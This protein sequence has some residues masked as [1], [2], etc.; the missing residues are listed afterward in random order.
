MHELNEE[1]LLELQRLMTSG[2]DELGDLSQFFENGLITR[3]KHND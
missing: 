2:D 3:E 1:D